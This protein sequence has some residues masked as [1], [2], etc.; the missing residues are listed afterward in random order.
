VKSYSLVRC[1]DCGH[2]EVRYSNV[3]RC[4]QCHGLIERPEPADETELR[5]LRELRT[6]VERWRESGDAR[7][8]GYVL[9]MLDKLQKQFPLM[10][11]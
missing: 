4:R 3:K 5:L 9:E 1:R 2:E 6:D 8:L 7:D 10:G 11:G